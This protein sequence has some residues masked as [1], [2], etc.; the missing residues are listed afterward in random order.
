MPKKF[1]TVFFALQMKLWMSPFT[2]LLVKS[3]IDKE[4]TVACQALVFSVK[5]DILH[6]RGYV[7]VQI[8]G[9]K[10]NKLDEHHNVYVL[11]TYYLM[12]WRETNNGENMHAWK[13]LSFL[14]RLWT[15]L[16][17]VSFGHGRVCPLNRWMGRLSYIRTY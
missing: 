11:C 3:V 4:K 17:R 9:F 8:P 12:Y 6:G 16:L 7:H 15:S 5:G 14:W 1:A 2:Y 13:K 10:L